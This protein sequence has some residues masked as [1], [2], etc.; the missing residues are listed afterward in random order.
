MEALVRRLAPQLEGAPVRLSVILPGGGHLGPQ[1][2]DVT[3][4]FHA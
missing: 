1:D 2:A 3:L 4:W